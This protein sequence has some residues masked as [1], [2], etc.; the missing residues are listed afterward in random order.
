MY[1]SLPIEQCTELKALL[2]VQ[3]DVLSALD[4]EG[5]VVVLVML[6]LSAAFAWIRSYLSDRLQ[7]VNTTGTLSD[8]QRLSFGVPYGLVLGQILYCLYTKPVFDTIW[9]LGLLHHS[10]ADDT[11][12][13]IAIKKQY[14]FADKLSDVEDCVFRNQIMDGTQLA[15]AEWW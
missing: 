8:K 12:I 14:C 5:T 10:Y 4:Q 1:Y 9:H 11:Q 15:E 7:R 6:D 13:Y 2:E 3:N